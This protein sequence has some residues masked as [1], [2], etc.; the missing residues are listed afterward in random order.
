MNKTWNNIMGSS[1]YNQNSHFG[2]TAYIKKIADNNFEYQ[3][4]EF[5]YLFDQYGQI[6]YM[7]KLYHE[8][9]SCLNEIDREFLFKFS[10]HT[11][12]DKRITRSQWEKYL[13]VKKKIEKFYDI[14]LDL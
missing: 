14:S 4:L 11:D 9:S 10:N 5:H 12:Y 2:E 6:E 7:L 1:L 8:D 3:N 13:D